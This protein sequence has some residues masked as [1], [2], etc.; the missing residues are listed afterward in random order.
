MRTIPW[1]PFVLLACVSPLPGG[2]PMTGLGLLPTALDG[3]LAVP[4]IREI[5][6]GEES[7]HGARHQRCAHSVMA[8]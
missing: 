6:E 8:T 4:P 3:L 1:I 5:R 7:V 2:D